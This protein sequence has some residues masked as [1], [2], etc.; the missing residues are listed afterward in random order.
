MLFMLIPLKILFSYDGITDVKLFRVTNDLEIEK[1]KILYGYFDL[2]ENCENIKYHE[3][4]KHKEEDVLSAPTFLLR[5]LKPEPRPKLNC[6][7]QLFLS[8][9]MVA[10]LFNLSKY[11]ACK[12]IITWAN[13]IYFKFCTYMTN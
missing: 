6:V 5:A 12:Y 9:I 1:F 10:C 13:F 4:A 8:F 2:R 3:C 11:T 7:D